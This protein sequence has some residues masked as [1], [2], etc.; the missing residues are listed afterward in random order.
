VREELVIVGAGGFA[1]EVAWI[2]LQQPERWRVR[3]FLDDNPE[4][5]GGKVLGLPV[6]GAVASFKAHDDAKFTIARGAPRARH[7]TR[8]AMR[9]VDDGR[10]ATLIDPSV[11]HHESVRFGAGS[12]ICAGVVAT[13]DIQMGKHA[14]VN[15]NATIGHECSIG[16]FCTI[17]PLAAISGN[18]TCE[19]GVEIGTGATIRQGTR[20]GRGALVGMGAVVTR[21]VAPNE[22]VAGNPARLLRTL[23]AFEG[24]L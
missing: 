7:E 20:I 22:C 15:L 17:A 3:G 18:V 5:N 4:L 23:P 24:T 12:I 13:I 19:D 2:A 8:H 21:D 6:L 1:Q 9:S 14:I 11:R 10:F 16:D